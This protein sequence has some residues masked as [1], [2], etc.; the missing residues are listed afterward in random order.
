MGESRER[1]V[2]NQQ[3]IQKKYLESKVGHASRAEKIDAK[4]WEKGVGYP[5][6]QDKYQAKILLLKEIEQETQQENSES[7]RTCIIC[8]Q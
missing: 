3:R 8:P 2:Q 1:N 4:H 7:R 5:R 6:P